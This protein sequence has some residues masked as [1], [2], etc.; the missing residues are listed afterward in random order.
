[1]T[2][3]A[4]WRAVAFVFGA[5]LS[6]SAMAV[7]GREVG[8]DLQTFEIMTYRSLFGLFF[9]VTIAASFGTLRE[10][11]TRRLGLHLVR[12]VFHF[13]GQNLWFYAVLYIPLSQLFAFE[14][15]TPLWIAI[16]APIFLGEHLSRLRMIG[17][18]IGFLGILI[19]ARPDLSTINWATLAALTCAI[20]FAGTS[21]TTKA[22]TQTESLTCILFWLVVMQAVFGLAASYWDGV[23]TWPKP[24]HWPYLLGIGICGLT[25]HFCL[26]MALRLAD[27]SF[28]APLEFLRLP[29]IAVIGFYL[30]GEPLLWTV[31]V[32]SLLVLGGNYLNIRDQRVQNPAPSSV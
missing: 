3:G 11:S 16:L 21:I 22:L 30:Y 25:A 32:G 19:V 14:F 28:V 8:Q 26:T 12:N 27:A 18:G 15:A 20:G 13:S 23:I 17:I 29:L 1:M 10:I 7:M 31:L 2:P 24:W 6:F 5:M 9:V 4:T